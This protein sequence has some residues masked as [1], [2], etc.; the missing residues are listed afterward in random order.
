MQ[1]WQHKYMLIDISVYPRVW[2]MSAQEP[3][4][5]QDVFFFFL[6][7]YWISE[8]NSI[9]TPAIVH[10]VEK[11][12]WWAGVWAAPHMNGEWWQIINYSMEAGKMRL[13]LIHLAKLIHV[14]WLD[15]IINTGASLRP[16][17]FLLYTNVC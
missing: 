5:L 2:R 12:K 1:L 3:G 16:R 14:L 13:I 6:N 10:N 7:I 17:F 15:I 8:K 4:P 9:Q 11:G